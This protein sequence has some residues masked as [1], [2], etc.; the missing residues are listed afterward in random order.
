MVDT[1]VMS[2]KCSSVEDCRLE[3]VSL[4]SVSGCNIRLL[5]RRFGIS[6]TTGY[7]WLARQGEGLSDRSRRPLSSPSQTSEFVCQLIL[8]VRSEHETWGARKIRQFL[9]NQGHEDLPSC[10]TVTEILRRS[11]WLQK[12]LSEVK[13]VIRFER[14]EANLLWQM[15]FKGHFATQVGPRCHPLTLLDDHS[16]YALCIQAFENENT[17]SVKSALV[18]VF[19][20]YGMPMQILCDNGS[21]WAGSTTHRHT[22][23]SVWLLT[24]GI[25]ICHG[26]PYHPQT[27][28]KLERFHRTLKA[29]V[30]TKRTYKDLDDCQMAFD[31]FRTIYNTQRP[32]EAIQME[33]PAKLYAVST[34]E[35]PQ[36]SPELF[37]APGGEIRKV[38]RP[39]E[40]FFK[41]K[42][43]KFAKAFIGF[44]VGLYETTQDGVWDVMFMG[45]VISQVDLRYNHEH[46]L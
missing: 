14:E 39:G 19:R 41:G 16:R 26:R 10:S 18:N 27:Q 38:Q 23:L 3:F 5:C 32:H 20:T 37:F 33:A 30:I 21:P 42:T 34:R 45:R 31:H 4:A 9:V 46:S 8:S 43:I 13:N 36:K 17:Q 22:P 15:D 40:I 29:D 28:G 35:F 7:K 24:H 12:H 1:F 44:P 25:D 2:W 6:P 11:G